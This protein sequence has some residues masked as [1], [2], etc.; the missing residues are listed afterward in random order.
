MV[1]HAHMPYIRHPEHEYFLEENWLY[2]AMSETYIPLLEMFSR[3]VNDGI[4]FSI[5]LSIS[6]TL[7][8]ML[9][10]KLL[11]DRYEKHIERQIDL[12][13]RE[14]S[15]VR[16]DTNFEPIV[17]MYRN[18]FLKNE[19]LFREIYKRNL[20]SGFRALQDEERLEIV[21]S[22]ATHAFLPNISQI[23]QAVKVQIKIGV[24]H[25]KKIFGQKP[26]GIWLPECGY[27]EKF[28][29]YI[30][31]EALDYFFL[32]THGIM[33]GTPVPRF[34]VYLPVKCPSGVFAFGRDIE[35]S[36]QVW[37]SVIGY[38]GDSDYREFYRD[39]GYDLPQE[40]LNSSVRPAGVRTFTGFKYYRITGKSVRKE[41]YD[42]QRASQKA[43]EHANDFI[44][45]RKNQIDL[46]AKKLKIKPVVTAMY[47]AELFGHWWFEGPEWIEYLLRGIAQSR[48]IFHTITPSEYLSTQAKTSQNIQTS[49]PSMSSWGERGYSEV[50]LNKYND[51]VYP[52]LH[53]ATE[54]MLILAKMFPHTTGIQK[55]ALNQSAREILLAQQSDWLFMMKHKNNS[56]YAK[57]RFEEHIQRFNALYDSITSGN[58]SEKLLADI[59]EKDRIFEDIDY[60]EFR[61]NM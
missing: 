22:P 34:G 54:R 5:T 19:Y 23:P 3:L 27:A 50:W 2:E 46:L 40:Y 51:Y 42:I 58:I 49:Q 26:S 21:T 28:D 35:T 38:P 29:E 33:Q 43:K 9:N 13:E 11:M 24:K 4:A 59:E 31:N 37:S 44:Q 57:K 53:K 36:K 60:K 30:K 61:N 41:P 56:S 48:T 45:K 6:P 47:D 8:E 15:R 10:D 16:G 7:I 1:L 17:Q 14:I 18:R 20:V 32:D 52:H 39:I 12:S 25:Y 55:R